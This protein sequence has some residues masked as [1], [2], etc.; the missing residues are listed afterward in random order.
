MKG[1]HQVLPV[2]W[3]C[4]ADLPERDQLGRHA[5]AISDLVARDHPVR[6]VS[7]LVQ[8]LICRHCAMR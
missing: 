7:A 5:A 1:L 3:G 6:A 4:G 8:G 2:L